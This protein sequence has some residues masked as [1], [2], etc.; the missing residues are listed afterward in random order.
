MILEKGFDQKQK[1]NIKK[2]TKPK[3][4]KKPRFLRPLI[5]PKSLKEI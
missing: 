5:L 4:L 2:F 1:L 3:K